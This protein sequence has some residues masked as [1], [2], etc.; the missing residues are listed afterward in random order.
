[1][2]MATALTDFALAANDAIAVTVDVQL[3]V[4]H[5]AWDVGLMHLW[6]SWI[7]SPPSF[8]LLEPT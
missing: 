3:L 2:I 8:Q 7:A 1:M 4:E 6:A 5:S